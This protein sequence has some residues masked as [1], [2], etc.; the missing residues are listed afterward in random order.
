MSS[1]ICS[2]IYC[3]TIPLVWYTCLYTIKPPNQVPSNHWVSTN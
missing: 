1:L 3:Y 2:F